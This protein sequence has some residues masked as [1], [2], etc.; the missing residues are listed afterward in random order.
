MR[1]VK[2]NRTVP[3]RGCF[4][5]ALRVLHE[6]TG[7]GRNEVARQAGIAS[8]NYSKMLSGQKNIEEHQLEKILIALGKTFSDLSFALTHHTDFL[9]KTE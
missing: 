4:A 5:K 3:V 8:G 7:I 2:K 6:E 1:I 9:R